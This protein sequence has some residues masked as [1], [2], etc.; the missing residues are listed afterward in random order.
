MCKSN[1]YQQ[2]IDEAFARLASLFPYGEAQASM[3]MAS[4]LN[5]VCDEIIMLRK[6]AGN[7]STTLLP[8][9]S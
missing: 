6:A 8:Q 1:T 4:F 2:K 9:S 3:D 5:A 7:T